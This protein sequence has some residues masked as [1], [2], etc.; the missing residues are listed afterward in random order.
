LWGHLKRTVI[1]NVLFHNI[2]DLV[3][4][5]R[6]GVGRVNGHRDR[7]NFVFDHDDVGKKAA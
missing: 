4:A 5:F 7:M 2:N 1:A 3:D 6:R